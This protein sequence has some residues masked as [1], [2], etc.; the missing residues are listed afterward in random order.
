MD[1]NVALV[2]NQTS[3]MYDGTHLVNT[4]KSLGVN[5]AENYRTWI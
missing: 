3:T 1:K 5:I 4:L 2:V